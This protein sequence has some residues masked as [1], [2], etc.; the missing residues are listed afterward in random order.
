[1]PEMYFR[2]K[3]PNSVETDHY[4]PSMVIKDYFTLDQELEVSEFL[5][6]IRTALKIAS[7]RVK[8]KYGFACSR[9]SASLAEI[10][11][12]ATP[13]LSHPGARIRVLELSR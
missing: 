6:R 7:D 3:W 8:A 11:S 9:A 12:A 2:V 13:F 1:M 10:E 4:S 5:D